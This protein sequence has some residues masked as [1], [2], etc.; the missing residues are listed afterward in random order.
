MAEPG[1]NGSS[2]PA[3]EARALRIGV[4]GHRPAGL[5]DA[6]LATVR[7]RVREVFAAA[8]AGARAGRLEVISPVAEGADRLVAREALAAGL[9]L[10][11]PLPFDRE[12]YGADFPTAGSRADY[13]ALLLAAARVVELAG[14]RAGPETTAAAY[15]AVGAWL[16]AHSDVLLAVWDGA[17]PRGEG[18]TG[19]VV[20]EALARC[21]PVVWI[22]ARP[23]HAVRVVTTAGDGQVVHEPLDRLSE[24]LGARERSR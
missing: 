12:A 17:A 4:T 8:R 3:G 7:A 16:L 19:Q 20:R 18:G 22:D 9:P 13:R 14:S 2:E 6:D 1:R 15:A 21:L 5:V 11:C 10:I 23:P 24:R